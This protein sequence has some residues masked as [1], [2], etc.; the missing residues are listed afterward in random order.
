[1]REAIPFAIV[2]TN[3]CADEVLPRIFSSPST[4]DNVIDRQRNIA[5]PTVLTAV[6][7][8]AKDV[9][10]RENDFLVGDTD[11]DREANDARERHRHGD[12]VEKSAI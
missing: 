2:A 8:A 6:A 7:I 1:V 5:S 12:G 11:V 4:R 9:L 10:A 3:A